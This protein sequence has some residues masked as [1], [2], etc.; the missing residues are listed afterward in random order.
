MS[1]VEVEYDD[2]QVG[3]RIRITREITV[4]KV[5]E[6]KDFL[7]DGEGTDGRTFFARGAKLE[8][9]PKPLD[10]PNKV[11]SVVRVSRGR[12]GTTNTSNWMLAQSGYWNSDRGG[13]KRNGTEFEEFI[14]IGGFDV[15][16][17][18]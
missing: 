11:G 17:I 4:S 5:F 13:M 6:N 14:E 12:A 1:A 2:I 18:A 7:R 16:V 15:E 9:L 10:L 3:D 8:R